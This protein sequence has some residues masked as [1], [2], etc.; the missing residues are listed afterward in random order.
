[1]NYLK[2]KIF[3]VIASTLLAHSVYAETVVSTLVDGGMTSGVELQCTAYMHMP[4]KILQN[5]NLLPI[6]F[7]QYG[8]GVG[9]ETSSLNHDVLESG[10]IA[11]EYFLTMDK[12]GIKPDPNFPTDPTKHIIDH[13]QYDYY[14]PDN[15]GTCA[16]N[17]LYWAFDYLK[18]E[19]HPILLHGLSE[20]SIVVANMTQKILSNN[21]RQDVKNNLKALFLSGIVMDKMIDVLNYQVKTGA[22]SSDTYK[23]TMEAYNNRD[24][25]S[26]FEYSQQGVAWFDYMFT[27]IASTKNPPNVTD[28]LDSLSTTKEGR[29]LSI[30][31]LQGLNDKEVNP[32]SVL[33]YE[34]NNFTKDKGQKLNLKARYYNAGHGLDQ[35]DTLPDIL[36]MQ[37]TGYSDLHSLKTTLLKQLKNG[38]D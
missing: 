8:S 35:P 38:T 14:S 23:N 5:S 19:N 7:V 2:L 26:L 30:E 28:I 1:M 32:Q 13:N 10:D 3:T 36:H 21:N 25:K 16:Q 15:L 11:P 18:K 4:D 9:I 37:A 34:K 33:N 29:A 12:P 24:N 31:I 20:G 22:M 17:A 27:P 6:Y